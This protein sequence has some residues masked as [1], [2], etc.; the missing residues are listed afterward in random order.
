MARC[1]R[2]RRYPIRHCRGQTS[3]A[4]EDSV[5]DEGGAIGTEAEGGFHIQMTGA[6]D[7]ARAAGLAIEHGIAIFETIAVGIMTENR[8][9]RMKSDP[10]GIV[11]AIG[12]LEEMCL[13]DLSLEILVEVILTPLRHCPRTLL[14]L[15]RTPS[16]SK[17]V[18]SIT[19]HCLR[20]PEE[21][22][23]LRHTQ[24]NKNQEMN[25]GIM[26]LVGR[27]CLGIQQPNKL[28]RHP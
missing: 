9:A 14:R 23:L 28:R 1:R 20:V 17:I 21:P 15:R 4:G 16:D 7:T 26:L 10:T 22:R 27:N 2:H 11:T 6:R 8:D 13:S 19:Y 24:I 18:P 25:L 3:T 12:I 5:G